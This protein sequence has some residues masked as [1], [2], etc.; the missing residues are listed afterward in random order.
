MSSRSPSGAVATERNS[1]PLSI[2]LHFV[3]RRMDPASRGGEQQ[4]END[5]VSALGHAERGTEVKTLAS[6]VGVE[7]PVSAALHRMTR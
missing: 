4:L 7:H 5:D 6:E 2:K 3:A 1:L